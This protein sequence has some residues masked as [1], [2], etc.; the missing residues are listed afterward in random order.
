MQKPML[1]QVSD[2]SEYVL[3]DPL[4]VRFRDAARLERQ[5]KLDQVGPLA[6]LHDNVEVLG[7]LQHLTDLDQVGVAAPNYEVVDVA[8]VRLVR[9]Q[10]LP[11]LV[12]ALDGV[13]LVGPPAHGVKHHRSV[14]AAEFLVHLV[15]VVDVGNRLDQGRLP[16]IWL[17]HQ[18]PGLTPIGHAASSAR[19]RVA[20]ASWRGGGRGRGVARH[21]RHA[22]RMGHVRGDGGGDARGVGEGL[23]LRRLEGGRRL[24]LVLLVGGSRV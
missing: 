2:S 12:D 15:D 11:C 5:H 17:R 9:N 22:E 21:W 7:V 8:E 23:W 10:L 6:L 20:C 14:S 24:L 16:A 13:L 4:A 1:M 3:H 18:P 19:R